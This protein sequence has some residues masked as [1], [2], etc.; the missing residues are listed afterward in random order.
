MQNFYELISCFF[1]LFSGKIF[2]TLSFGLALII[3]LQPSK[4]VNKN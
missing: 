4:S 1:F 3:E 2:S